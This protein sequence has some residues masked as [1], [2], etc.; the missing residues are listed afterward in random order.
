MDLH[1]AAAGLAPNPPGWIQRLELCAENNRLPNTEMLDR[2]GIETE[3]EIPLPEMEAP[4]P[5]PRAASPAQ[6]S[7]VPANAPPF[8]PLGPAAPWLG[9]EYTLPSPWTGTTSAL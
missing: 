6:L 2:K 9:Q 4:A 7:A 1:F 8:L 3:V 5:D